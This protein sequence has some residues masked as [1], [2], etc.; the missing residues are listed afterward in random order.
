MLLTIAL[1]AYVAGMAGALL[2]QRAERV[3]NALG[4]GL[5]ALGGA[6]GV[7]FSVVS[8]AAGQAMT[9]APVTL[10]S[11]PIPAVRLVVEVDAL[12]CFFVL[13]V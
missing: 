6:C 3:A 7:V 13:I 10:W 4:F 9:S 12:S 11:G 5:A 8:L 2:T 1:V